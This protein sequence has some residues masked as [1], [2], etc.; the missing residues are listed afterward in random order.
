MIND[1][2]SAVKQQIPKFNDDLIIDLRKREIVNL[3]E[4]I[5]ER[6]KECCVVADENLQLVQ[7]RILSPMER[8]CHELAM[9]A[10]YQKD[11]TIKNNKKR[12]NSISIETDETILV[13]YVFRYCDQ[14]FSVPLYIPYIYEDSCLV[15]GNKR[16]ECML[17]VT[18]KLFSVRTGSNGVTIKVIR[19]PISFYKNTPH[20][21]VDEKTN[22]SFV[23]SIVT[24]KIHSN[25][26]PKSKRAKATIIHYLLCKY[27]IPEMLMKFDIQ[28]DALSLVE[29]EEFDDDCFYF[30]IKNTMTDQMYLKI[31]KSLML[32]NRLLYDIT[33]T[34]CYILSGFRFVLY[35]DLINDSKTVFKII[36][37]KII[38][39]NSTDQ[40]H[41]LNYMKRH[42]ESVDSYLDNYT[43]NLFRSE[44][45]II[46][47]IYDLLIFIQ[48]NISKIIIDY[49]N[50][51]MYN[52]RVEAINN[53][54][55]DGLA[56][57]L[58]R[59][60]YRIERKDDFAHMLK[61]LTKAFSIHPQAIQKSLSTSESVRFSSSGIYSDNWL[62][63]IGDK[64]LKR[65]SATMKQSS[66]GQKGKKVHSSGINAHVNK[67][68][69]SMLVVESPIGFSSKPGSNCLVNPFTMIDSTGGFVRPSSAA[70]IDE[71]YKYLTND[72][73]GIVE[74]DHDSNEK[75]MKELSDE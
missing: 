68:H 74:D 61:S 50:N 9:A 51:N 34:I 72:Q 3:A 24:S 8:I 26:P 53:V 71:I 43:K 58:N 14:T 6:F 44:G 46:N 27:S 22:E 29:K 10:K 2:M 64:V 12:K 35:R 67:F 40:V 62:L 60:I 45:I 47:D 21:F 4:F 69:P 55:V 73:Q 36:L 23:G 20:I 11:A 48:L 63:T 65:L 15:V 37:G 56:R 28:P 41:A 32:E 18:E 13:A 70:D 49:P 42:I 52:K 31:K 75:L 1:I 39:G 17:N 7:Y 30:R 38:H 66:G 5:A 57:T 54:I 59:N 25:E 33:A 19:A 16:Y